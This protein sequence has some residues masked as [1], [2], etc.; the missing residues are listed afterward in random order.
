M[1]PLYIDALFCRCSVFWRQAALRHV[2][3]KVWY[4]HAG[5]CDIAGARICAGR[6][7]HHHGSGRLQRDQPSAV[8]TNLVSLFAFPAVR[9]AITKHVV[10]FQ[11]HAVF[12]RSAVTFTPELCHCFMPVMLM[13]TCDMRNACQTGEQ[14]G[15]KRLNY[16]VLPC[17]SDSACSISA[18]SC[19]A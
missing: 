16:W 14:Q 5:T 6:Q 18:P 4:G 7:H 1:S 15:A 10:G 2:C 12:Q 13:R 3:S 9:Y 19:A 8:P 17:W 11:R